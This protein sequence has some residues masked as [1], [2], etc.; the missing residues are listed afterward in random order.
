MKQDYH[1]YNNE[2]LVSSLLYGVLRKVG[3]LNVAII[4]ALLPLVLDE[5]ICKF[6]EIKK[7][8]LVNILQVGRNKLL[9][10]NDQ[11][12]DVF[13]I[14]LNGISVLMDLQLVTLEGEYLV[15]SDKEIQNVCV[16]DCLRLDRLIKVFYQLYRDAEAMKLST[17]YTQ[18]NIKL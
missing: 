6:V 14:M 13:P 16:D 17:L 15:L 4:A 1:V 11:Y 7:F 3:R 9:N 2:A 5:T 12:Y 18:L 8:V 10:F